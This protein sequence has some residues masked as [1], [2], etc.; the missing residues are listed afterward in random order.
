MWRLRKVMLCSA[1][2]LCFMLY[3]QA[4]MQCSIS[5]A[6][7]TQFS[8]LTGTVLHTTVDQVRPPHRNIPQTEANQGRKS[9]SKRVESAGDIHFDLDS[10]VNKRFNWSLC[11]SQASGST[12]CCCG[13]SNWNHYISFGPPTTVAAGS[14]DLDPVHQRGLSNGPNENI[15]W[16]PFIFEIRTELLSRWQSTVLMPFFLPCLI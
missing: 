6:L 2:W 13:F 16:S 7:R 15:E 9:L 1:L 5:G 10:N 4:T 8:R 11:G 12:Y 14:S 3:T